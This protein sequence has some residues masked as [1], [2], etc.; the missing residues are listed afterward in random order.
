MSET[1]TQIEQ[2]PAWQRINQPTRFITAQI[3]EFI[4]TEQVIADGEELFTEGDDQDISGAVIL[5]GLASIS[6]YLATTS[7]TLPL[8]HILVRCRLWSPKHYAFI[9]K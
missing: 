3:L 2:I 5:G 7:P 4:G 9:T 1:T 6:D 8:P